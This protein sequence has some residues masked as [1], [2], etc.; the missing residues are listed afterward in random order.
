MTESNS[1]GRSISPNR[2]KEDIVSKLNHDTHFPKVYSNERNLIVYDGC[3]TLSAA[4]HPLVVF[5]LNG[6]GW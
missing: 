1:S 3:L 4:F 2:D 6:S 5:G